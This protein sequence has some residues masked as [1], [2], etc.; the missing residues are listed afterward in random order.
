[1]DYSDLSKWYGH[2]S[3][4]CR[5]L[6]TLRWQWWTLF[7]KHFNVQN[8][9]DVYSTWRKVWGTSF[10]RT[11]FCNATMLNHGLPSGIYTSLPVKRR[12]YILADQR[13]VTIVNDHNNRDI[14]EY[15]RGIRDELEVIMRTRRLL[16]N[17]CYRAIIM[18]VSSLHTRLI[19]IKPLLNNIFVRLK[20]FSNE[21]LSMEIA[22]FKKRS[23]WY[24]LYLKNACCSSGF[25]GWDEPK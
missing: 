10:P 1:M 18:P 22:C 4:Q 9:M 20:L 14:I 23:V 13:L 5:S 17:V 6:S 19:H 24:E 21:N 2:F 15:L 16:R 11:V 3:I 12:E 25:N 7:D 8:F